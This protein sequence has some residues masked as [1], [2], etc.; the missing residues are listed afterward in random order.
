[1]AD[2][3]VLPVHAKK[4]TACTAIITLSAPLIHKGLPHSVVGLPARTHT[5][6]GVCHV[7]T[8][9]YCNNSSRTTDEDSWPNGRGIFPYFHHQSSR[10]SSGITETALRYACTRHQGW[11]RE[12]SGH[13]AICIGN[14]IQN[15]QRKIKSV[16]GAHLCRRSTC[17]TTV[18]LVW[19]WEP[20][21]K[22]YTTSTRILQ[23]F[24]FL[25]LL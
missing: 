10:H 12:C 17:H 8:W 2:D 18:N 4:W 11:V 5:L 14:F 24:T 16:N 1:M 21:P 3:F 22:V 20:Y 15:L 7:T 13:I 25:L 23:R 6:H 9:T 19:I